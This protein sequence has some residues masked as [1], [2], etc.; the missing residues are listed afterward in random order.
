M[1]THLSSWQIRPLSPQDCVQLNQYKL[2]DEIG[3]VNILWLQGWGGN[4][5]WERVGFALAFNPVT[6]IVEF[7]PSPWQLPW[8][9][10]AM[11]VFW[12]CAH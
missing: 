7:S 3:K 9:H 4:A 5:G 1:A 11:L 12:G 6:S 2:K 8:L 10:A